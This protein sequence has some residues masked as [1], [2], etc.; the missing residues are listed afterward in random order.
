M[1]I[2]NFCNGESNLKLSTVLGYSTVLMTAARWSRVLARHTHTHTHLQFEEVIGN[3]NAKMLRLC[4]S[5]ISS[6]VYSL[7]HRKKIRIKSI[8]T[9]NLTIEKS[10]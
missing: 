9:A 4:N 8:A 3:F 5:H 2:G 1:N 7:C 6:G 10:A